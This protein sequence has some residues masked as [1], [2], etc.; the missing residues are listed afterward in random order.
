MDKIINTKNE[1]L[2]LIMQFF[3]PLNSPQQISENNK[4]LNILI[5]TLIK[6]SKFKL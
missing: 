3:A 4:K 6:E 1:K 2:E 5:Q